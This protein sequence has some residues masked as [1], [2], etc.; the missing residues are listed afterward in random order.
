MTVKEHA[1]QAIK[2]LPE[3]ADWEDVKRKID[4][5]AAVEK[6]LSDLEQGKG[7]PV[8]SLEQDLQKW[9]SR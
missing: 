4:F 1:L 2:S 8:E 3:N 5:R 6:G 7:V 9:I